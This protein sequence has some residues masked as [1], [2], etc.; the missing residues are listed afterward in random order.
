MVFCQTGNL[1]FQPPEVVD[2]WTEIYDATSP[3]VGC[4]QSMSHFNGTSGSLGVEDCLQINVY[5]ADFEGNAPVMVC[6]VWLVLC[7]FFI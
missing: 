7:Y 1:R 2:P 3:S 5:T 6:I 4:A